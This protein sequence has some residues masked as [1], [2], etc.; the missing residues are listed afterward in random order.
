MPTSKQ[1]GSYN[2]HGEQIALRCIMDPIWWFHLLQRKRDKE[3]KSLTAAMF[4]FFPWI[5]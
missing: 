2:V 1:Q 3:I 5:Q 4:D